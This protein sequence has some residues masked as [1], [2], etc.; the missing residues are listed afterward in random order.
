MIELEKQT[1][2]ANKEQ[3]INL[4]QRLSREGS[5]DNSDISSLILY[6]MA[7]PPKP[8]NDTMKWLSNACATAYNEVRTVLKHI[9]I[10]QGKAYA[11]DGHRL[12]CIDTDLSDGFYDPKTF[13]PVEIDC[14]PYR[15][16]EQ[17]AERAGEKKC[18][19]QSGFKR[20]VLADKISLLNEDMEVCVNEKYLLQAMNGYHTDEI[21]LEVGANLIRGRSEHGEWIVMLTRY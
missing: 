21:T 2:P 16:S 14:K 19:D 12:H 6:F 11:S 17:F 7:K 18:F 3:A 8:V 15:F 1:L 20:V 4:V 13:E 5:L 9:Y 10:E